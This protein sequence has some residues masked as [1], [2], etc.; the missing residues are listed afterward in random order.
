MQIDAASWKRVSALFDRLADLDASERQ[1]R[2]AELDLDD[3]T[4]SCLKQLLSAHDSTDPHV[5]D[6]TLD[7][8]AASLV[9]VDPDDLDEAVDAMAGQ[10]LGS[11]RVG[12]PIG[13]GAT[14]SVFHGERADGTYEQNVAIK[15]LHPGHDPS[16]DRDRLREEL[17]VLAR[18][19][20]PGIARLI[21][22]GFSD[23][24]RPFLVMEYVDGLQIDQWCER[25][26]LDW[27]Q[28]LQLIIRVCDAIRYAHGKL[29]VHADIKPSNVLVNQAGEPKLVDFGIA[30]LL[31]DD[32]SAVE[33]RQDAFLRCSPA[34]AAP[35][36][37]RGASVSTA[38]DV[39]G[40]GALLYELLVG[41]RVRDGQT[42]T[43]LLVDRTLPEAT[44]PPSSHPSPLTPAGVL[45][46]DLDAICSRALAADPQH[47]YRSI[48]P[49]QQDLEHHL[50]HL[51]V[52]ARP[53][54]RSYLLSRWL[55][56]HR[57]GAGLA[58]A[59]LLSLL[60]GLSVSIRQT[61]LA[62]ESARR[63]E[64]TTAFLLSV[65]EAD[66][67]GDYGAPLQSTRRDLATRAAEQLDLVADQ[68][69]EARI[70]LLIA[71]G[72]VLRKVGLTDQARALVQQG[73]V[74][75]ETLEF[76]GPAASLVS[77]W[78]ELGQIES[79]DERMEP[80]AEA[81]RQ[82][83]ALARS[84]N[85]P[86]VERAAILFQM[87]RV[88]S[89]LRRIEE[90][91]ATLD[92]AAVLAETSE[93]T[94]VLLPRIELL[95]ALTLNRGGRT[96][97]ALLTGERAVA[98]ARVI[99]GAD[100]ER[101][102]SALSTVGGMLRHTGQLD[103][104]EGMLRE[105][106]AIGQRNYG[107]AR[108]AVVNNLAL[109]METRGNLV[110]AE[111]VQT[112]ALNLAEAYYGRDSAASAR[113]RRNLGLIQAW[114]GD[115]EQALSNLTQAL[116][117]HQADAGAEDNYTLF[118]RSQLA[119]ARLQAGQID[120]VRESL[121]ALLQRLPTLRESNPRTAI[122]IHMLAAELSLH[123]SDG[124]TA[125]AH[126]DA[127]G[128]LLDNADITLSNWEQVYTALVESLA[129]SAVAAEEPPTEQW[130]DLL[131]L[132][133]RLL[134]VDHP[135]RIRVESVAAARGLTGIEKAETS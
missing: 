95:K 51:P 55:R 102:A 72:R 35:E 100:H 120:A 133:Q 96:Q 78:F 2:L 119:W 1:R 15:L 62:T 37:L 107:Q 73:I 53:R 7:Q 60:I 65:F 112:E 69:P 18:L 13:Q 80:A 12:Q 97:A 30:G 126:S 52:S 82:A 38:T 54:T 25:Q 89:A 88:L 93:E 111:S 94:R 63:A 121:P 106:Y 128:G 40:V 90:A 66:E 31:R 9:G 57:L 132:S 68:Q 70:E 43:T 17:R 87:G 122:W 10:R 118:M 98:S 105:A 20:H 16:G 117:I 61:L 92:D 123:N 83:D 125:R 29:V 5:L 58:A 44:A 67:P 49:L 104:A 131:E 46:G 74:E 50:G 84:M 11:W 21:D 79:L 114:R 113:Y 135:L 14:A 115:W 129:N 56:R 24:G 85:D 3:L 108:P 28:R 8:F 34:Y 47:R 99:F 4:D 23:Q 42:L 39:F 81:F 33:E 77:A 64:A 6:Q 32:S 124:Q 101:T 36:Q 22:G 86:P 103:R 110:E 26:D 76:D 71:I 130:Q 59:L 134:G 45:R 75:I 19:E 41:A 109:L 127:I 91:I 116:N 27:R 48:E